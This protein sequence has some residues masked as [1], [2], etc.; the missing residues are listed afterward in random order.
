MKIAFLFLLIDNPYFPD[1]WDKYFDNNDDKYNIYI[2]PKY[3][4]KHT[5]RPQNII[6]NIQDTA[7]G[8]VTRAYIELLSDAYR[9]KE[10]VKFI[11]V[12]ESCLPIRLF[13]IFYNDC[14]RDLNKSWIKVMNMS[15]YDKEARVIK[16]I[17]YIK[18]NK[19]NIIVP[20]LDTIIKH[21]ARFCLRREDVKKLIIA[22]KEGRMKFFN[23]MCVGDEFF[24]TT[25]TPLH[26]NEYVDFAVTF[27]DWEHTFKKV[28][29]INN[30]I[31]KAYKKIEDK[32][33]TKKDQEKCELQIKELRTLKSID[34][35]H[36]K[37]II[38]VNEDMKN[39]L[40]T[41]SYFYRKFAKNSNIREYWDK[42]IKSNKN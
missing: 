40:T 37:T 1:I 4:E 36:P 22:T 42:I 38:D 14:I 11:L 33:T 24:L 8:F 20:K 31:K 2:H 10:N 23:T 28:N 19:K 7:W 39:I 21:Y 34:A 17:N 15:K 41:K 3:P 18:E 12:S 27:D 16:H 32:N 25:I 9:N 26:K 35:N 30:L 5:W 6:K 29:N 13:N